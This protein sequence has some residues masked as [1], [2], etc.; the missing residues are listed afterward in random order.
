MTSRH[1]LVLTATPDSISAG[2][3]A[4]VLVEE[5]LAACCTLIDRAQSIYR[6]EGAIQEAMECVLLIK[7]AGDRVV[8]LQRRLV[9]L[10]PYDL[11]EIIVL[12]IEGGTDAYLDWI[13]ETTRRVTGG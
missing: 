6:W 4:H 9:E 12:P 8:E 11:P 3:I 13:S 5:R 2:S 1:V 10:H 7:S